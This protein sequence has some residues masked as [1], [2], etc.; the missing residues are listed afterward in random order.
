MHCIAI[1][2]VLLNMEECKLMI[3]SNHVFSNKQML[4]STYIKSDKES[5]KED[6]IN[7]YKLL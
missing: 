7:S 5:D 6:M 3:V 2:F 1:L 4:V